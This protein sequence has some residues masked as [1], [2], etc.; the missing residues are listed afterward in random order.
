MELL[1]R[2]L[3]IFSATMSI[4]N[5]T[6]SIFKINKLD[7]LNCKIDAILFLIYYWGFEATIHLYLK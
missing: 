1:L 4:V 5:L 2:A 6:R 3:Q 7:E